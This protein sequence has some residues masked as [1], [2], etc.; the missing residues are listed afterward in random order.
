MRLR[1]NELSISDVTFSVLKPG[2]YDTAEVIITCP[3]ELYKVTQ[4][5]RKPELHKGAKAEKPWERMKPLV[6]LQQTAL[7]TSLGYKLSKVVH[8]TQFLLLVT[9][10][11]SK[12]KQ[13]PAEKS[14]L[15]L[16]TTNRGLGLNQADADIWRL[17]PHPDFSKG[18]GDRKTNT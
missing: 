7:Q 2:T 8:R 9:T 12:I 18:T 6:L 15:P 17:L 10:D 3:S 13:Q 5:D 16:F 14:L 11:N 4:G 1:I